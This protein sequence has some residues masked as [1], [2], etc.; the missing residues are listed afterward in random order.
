VGIL[1]AVLGLS[2]FQERAYLF[3]L[4]PTQLSRRIYNV[5]PFPESVEIGRYIRE[6]SLEGD[7]IAVLGSEPQIYFYAR[8]RSATGYIYMYPLMGRH[9]YAVR[10]QEELIAEVEGNK[11]DFVVF[12]NIP[13]SWMKGDDSPALVWNWIQGYC[14]REYDLIGCVQILSADRTDYAWG[15]EASAYVPQK[16]D[17]VLIMR[18]KPAMDS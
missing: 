5:A 17:W 9:K 12:V 15:E 14:L 4:T 16:R 1:L 3:E 2:L 18:R 13:T 7:T 8:R 6:N 10:M 11:P